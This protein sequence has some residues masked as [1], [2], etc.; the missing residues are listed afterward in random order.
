MAWTAGTKASTTGSTVSNQLVTPAGNLY[1]ERRDFYLNPYQTAELYKSVSPFVTILNKLPSK[2]TKDPDYKMFEHRGDWLNQM[3]YI[4]GSGSWSNNAISNLTVE[5]TSG[6]SDNV[7]FLQKGLKF[8]VY[9][10]DMSTRKG[11]A[12][13]TNVDTQQ[14]I[15][16]VES[17]A[18]PS[19]FADGDVALVVGHAH[20]EGTKAPNA[21]S[22]ELEVTW[23]SASIFKTPV[24]ISGT[25]LAMTR[26]RG[27]SNELARLRSEMFK[28][29]KIKQAKSVYFSRR[30]DGTSAPDSSNN[31]VTDGSGNIIRNMHG[32]IPVLEDY[33]SSDD[34]SVEQNITMG[35]F[36]W[37]DFIDLMIEVFEYV[38]E[39]GVKY[40]MCGDDVLSFFS[41][42]GSSGFL[43]GSTN[44]ITLTDSVS[45]S[46]GLNLQTLVTP[47]GKL[48]LVRD[49]LFSQ[50]FVKGSTKPFSGWGVVLDPSNIYRVNFRNSKYQ[51]GLATNDYGGE[52]V[53]DQYFSDFGIM[54]L[55]PETF[56]L[57]KFS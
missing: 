41:K 6:G 17:E 34:S 39:Q 29:H 44:Q 53:K 21:Y 38:N 14:Q 26:L 55:L 24:K 40:L 47:F 35:N 33:A 9:S 31:Q 11:Q 13:I 22:D 52:L 28:V 25:L 51:T 37:D 19:D 5:A 15:D 42:I 4:G 56:K 43:D 7:G 36:Y 32:I 54:M 48:R 3:F 18:S 50:G 1:D 46:M 49:R 10:S 12:I 2:K 8:D 23:N 57:L 45:T 20:G 16:I 30:P 27:Y